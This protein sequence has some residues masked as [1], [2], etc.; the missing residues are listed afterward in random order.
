MLTSR[1][2]IGVVSINITEACTN[3]GFIT[4]IPSEQLSAYQIFY[5]MK[6]NIEMFKTM[7]SGATFKELTKS[8]FKNFKIVVPEKI[9]SKKFKDL[10]A[11]IMSLIL[12]LQIKNINLKQTCDLLLPKLISGKI[13]VSDLDLETGKP[14]E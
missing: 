9:I 3:Q 13:D 10:V 2:T 4:C 7:A 5:W 6:E 14:G 8:V 1:A 12:N 11:P